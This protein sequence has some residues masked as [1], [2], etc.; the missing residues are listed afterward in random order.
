MT[1]CGAK[2]CWTRSSS[3]TRRGGRW[4]C[5]CDLNPLAPF[6]WTE[7]DPA[8]SPERPYMKEELRAYLAA[9]RRTCHATL[10][11]LTEE[12]ADRGVSWYG[13]TRGRTVSYLEVQLHN[14]R[15]VQE[16]AS[17]LS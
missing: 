3:P 4:H 1:A 2:R 8:V 5:R 14:L 12:Q 13:W 7:G 11:A 17:Q 15:H 6:V 16:H 10:S 9:L